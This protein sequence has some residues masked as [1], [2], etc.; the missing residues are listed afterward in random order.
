MKTGT[1][2]SIGMRAVARLAWLGLLAGVCSCAS[3]PPPAGGDAPP[4]PKIRFLITYD[5]GPSAQVDNSTLSILSQLATNDVQSGICAI[6]FTQPV[7]PRGGALPRGREVMRQ[8]SAQGH[9]VGIHSVSPRGHVAHPT[10]PTNEL[11][12]LLINAKRIIRD[13]CGEEPV[14]VRPPYGTHNWATRAVYRNLGLQMLLGDMSAR[15][16]VI[17]GFNG[18]PTRRIHIRHCLREIR[19]D[20]TGYPVG[21]EPYP[22]VM[23]F[24]DVNPYTARHMTEY[25]HILTEEAARVGLVL[26]DKP[27]Y[28]TRREAEEAARFR[29]L[30]PPETPPPATNGVPRLNLSV[31]DKL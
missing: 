17:Y 2:H 9:I 26:P 3:L 28:G 7:H 16:G 12:T 1:K 25:L 8:M 23:S 18:S 30:P 11:A 27:F 29:C 5:D 13:T 15:D 19:E 4:P 31:T 20:L 21:A 6:F 14:F 22:I 10:I 24:H